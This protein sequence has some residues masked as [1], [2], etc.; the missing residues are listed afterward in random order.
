MSKTSPPRPRRRRLRIILGVI[1]VVAVAGALAVRSPSPVGHWRSAEGYDEFQ[2]AYAEAM[3][4]MPEPDETIDV[5][6]DFGLVRLYRFA[7]STERSTPLVLVTGHG[8]GSAVWAENMPSLL[9][10]GDVYAVDLLGH[11][12]MSVQERPI[13]DAADQAL[14]MHQALEQLPEDRFHLIGLSIGGWTATNYATRHPELV[15]SVSL[16]DPVFT[17]ANISAAF[18]VRSIPAAISWLPKSWRDNFNSW[19]A[20]GGETDDFAIGRMI[21]SGQEHYANKLPQPEQISEEALEA[22]DIP[23]LAII[24][25]ES[26]VHDAESAVEVA[27]R[28]LAHGTVEL[29]EGATHAVSAQEAERVAADI[30][31]LLE[32]LD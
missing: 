4:E 24:A 23:V 17:F 27:E 25:E 8:S 3:A 26:V 29:Y 22:L 6:T 16:I 7:G 11:P 31:T 5:R 20:G 30:G 19:I 9:E 14:W 10:L 21:D 15:A 2:V 13:T 28:T 32:G 12:G 18:V 1:A